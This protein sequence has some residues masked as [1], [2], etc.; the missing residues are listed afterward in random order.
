ME[1]F[2]KRFLVWLKRALFPK[3][4]VA[5]RTFDTWLCPN[6]FIKTKITTRLTCPKCGATSATGSFCASHK[7]IYLNGLWYALP[8]GNKVAR[9]LIHILKYDGVVEISKILSEFITLIL[10]THNLPP[11][12][13]T[14]PKEKWQIVPVPL[15]PRRLRDRGFN[16]A[17]LIAQNILE[18]NNLQINLLLKKSRATKPQA[19]LPNKKRYQNIKNSYALINPRDLSG[20]IFILLDDV[21]T[22]G[23][24]LNNC[25]RVLKEHGA[26]E[27]W[28]LTVAK[29]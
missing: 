15:H 29:G 1:G 19:K 5:C 7:K 27:V 8:Y 12:W 18:K 13:H 3:K 28:A 21:Y 16:Q 26:T 23:A 4:C 6:C 22:S 25:A 9:E 20:Q 14:Q 11:A 17:Y 24:T 10:A 2:I